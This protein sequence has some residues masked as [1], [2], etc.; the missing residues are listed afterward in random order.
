MMNLD[1]LAYI[2]HI[3]VTKSDHGVTNENVGY[4]SFNLSHFVKSRSVRRVV[5]ELTVYDNG[6]AVYKPMDVGS[7]TQSD[8]NAVASFVIRVVKSNDLS[9]MVR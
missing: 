8:V 1:S 4:T 9:L 2:R 6:T 7:A 5:G 3:E